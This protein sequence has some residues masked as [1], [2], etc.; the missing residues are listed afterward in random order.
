MRNTT[1]TCDKCGKEILRDRHTIVTEHHAFT[2][3]QVITGDLCWPCH[4]L[5]GKWLKEAA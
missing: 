2:A 4:I 3:T 1:T 5:L